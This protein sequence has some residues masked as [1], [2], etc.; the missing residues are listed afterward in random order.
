MRSAQFKRLIVDK[1][2][3]EMVSTC[4]LCGFKIEQ[5]ITDGRKNLEDQEWEHAKGC[6]GLEAAASS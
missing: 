6:K 1:E 4:Q 2:T 3:G 5:L